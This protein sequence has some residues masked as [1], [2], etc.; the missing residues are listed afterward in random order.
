MTILKNDPKIKCIIVDDEPIAR[1]VIDGHINKISE[2]EC[3]GQFKNA[4]E[5]IS[6][7]E[8]RTE[9]FVIFLDINMPNLS[10]IS[11]A[12]ILKK[13]HLVIFTTAYSEYAVE[14]YEHNAVDYLL[15]PITF[16]RFA[17]A[18]L[19]VKYRLRKSTANQSQNLENQSQSIYIKSNGEN[20]LT[21]LN[22]IKYCEASKNYTKIFLTNN[23]VYSTLQSI[24]TVE[25][26]VKEMSNSFIRV[27]RSYLIS[28]LFVKSFGTR[29]VIVDQ[30]KIPI[31]AQ[32][33]DSFFLQI[34][35]INK[36]EL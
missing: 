19:K 11:M 25:N 30:T 20:F 15:K 17:Q 8:S 4:I 28:K 35:F 34:N 5:A 2:L 1:Q 29:H 21:D 13:E 9:I 7:L 12:K 36:S 24:S 32:Y 23:R 18:F 31:G 33:K 22:Q 27:H 14:S 3:E 16:D 26:R 10:G 6:F